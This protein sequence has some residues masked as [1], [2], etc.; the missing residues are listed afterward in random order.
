[1]KLNNAEQKLRLT[2]TDHFLQV[3]PDLQEKFYIIEST[4]RLIGD[5]VK[6]LA[7]ARSFIMHTV[8]IYLYLLRNWD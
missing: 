5:T 4:M 7:T 2:M 3:T 1:M 6:R 8:Y